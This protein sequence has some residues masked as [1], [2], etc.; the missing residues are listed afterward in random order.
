MDM[1]T[2]TTAAFEEAYKTLNAGQK[3]AVDTTEGPVMVLAGPG[4]GKTQ[5]LAVRIGNILQKTQL[6]PWNI[7]CLTFTE[8]AATEM[9]ERLAHMMGSVAYSIRISTFHAFCNDIIQENPDIFAAS[10]DIQA[11]EDVEQF[12][13]V[14]ELIDELPGTSVL[15]PSGNVYLYLKDAIG[16]IQKLKQEDIS[17]EAFVDTLDRLQVFVD[18]VEKDVSV[19]IKVKANERTDG[20]CLAI[21]EK[22]EKAADKAGVPESIQEEIRTIRSSFE[23]AMDAADGKREQGKARTA[24]KDHVKRVVEQMTKH[25]PRQKELAMV[26]KKYQKALQEKSRY[27]FADMIINVVQKFKGNDA[28]LARYQEQF[29]YILVDEFQDTNGA[30]NEVVELLGSYDNQPNI[31]VVGD[32][33]QSIYR[34]QGASLSNMLSFYERYREHVSVITLTDNYRS[35]APIITAASAVITHN[36]QSLAG[37]IPGIADELVPRAGYEEVLLDEVVLQTPDQ[38]IAEIAG[39][40]G[41]LQ[42]TGQDLREVA[43]LVHTNKDAQE[44]AAGLA[45]FAIPVQLASGENALESPAVQQWISIWRYIADPNANDHLLADIIQFDIWGIDTLESLQAIHAAGTSHDTVTK[46][47]SNTTFLQKAGL[48][49][50]EAVVGVVRRL[51]TWRALGTQ[52]TVPNLITTMLDESGWLENMSNKTA[53][54]MQLE[55]MSTVLDVAKKLAATQH[56]TTLQDF[57]RELNLHVRHDVALVT[58]PHRLSSHAVQVMTAHKSKGQEFDYVFIAR[59]I[60]GKWGGNR[61]RGVLPLPHGLVRYDV[62]A[63]DENNEDERRLFYVA[64]TRARK[65]VILT[66]S[67]VNGSEKTNAPSRF[68]TEIPRDVLVLTEKEETQEHALERLTSAQLA[69]PVDTSPAIQEWVRGLLQNYVMSVT[70]LNNYLDPDNGPQKFYMRNILRMPSVRTKHQAMGT[71]VHAALTSMFGQFAQEGKLPSK[72]FLLESFESYLKRE[73]LSKQEYSDA[74]EVG[75]KELADYYDRYKK[76]FVQRTLG[77]YDFRPHHIQVEGIP[78]TGKIDK[79]EFIDD[80]QVNVV[81]YKTGNPENGLKKMKPGQDYHRQI[82]FYQLLCDTSGQFPYEMVSGEVDFIRPNSKG[83]FIKKKIE[84][85]QK[86]KDALIEEMVRVWGEI[87]NLSFVNK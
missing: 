28:L 86:E 64:L 10:P 34:F 65:H 59:L 11:L 70:H 18:A 5:T 69:K 13:I 36:E 19:F 83:E 63:E 2:K 39:R 20:D 84:V 56:T 7:L 35:S 50:P 15:K 42:K 66:R 79:I 85:T 23:A 26:Y 8:A 22:L 75:Q 9:R 47:F 81:D 57:V 82:V 68:E 53:N 17:P 21:C 58:P 67:R 78:I 71:A 62:V 6:D 51:A 3:Q 12:E 45:Q 30:Q 80:K 49:N 52:T 61:R 32:D 37:A 40:I 33:K 46:A 54:L 43:V 87:Q 73:A 31:F 38:E 24:C 72:K 77:E 76:E 41:A 74:L 16:H 44:L 27:D 1:G 4:T 14:Q 29:Q 25:L 48:K 55:H 60:N